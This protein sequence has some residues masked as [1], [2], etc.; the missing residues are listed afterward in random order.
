MPA[1]AAIRIAVGAGNRGGAGLLLRSPPNANRAVEA[2]A[3]RATFT[4]GAVAQR[5][6]CDNHV[7][8]DPPPGDDD[9]FEPAPQAGRPAL[10][11]RNE[12]ALTSLDLVDGLERRD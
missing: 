1:P 2:R 11:E 7:R 10:D 8:A 6:E 4:I 5:I 3:V 12:R 9:T